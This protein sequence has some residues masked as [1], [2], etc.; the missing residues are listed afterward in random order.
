M[1]ILHVETGRH[2]YG[3]ARQVLDLLRGLRESGQDRGE[4]AC[5]ADGPLAEAAEPYARVTPLRFRGETDPRLFAGL[6]EV[7]RERPPDLIHIHSRRGADFWGLLAARSAGI[8]AVLSRRVDNPEPGWWARWKYGQCAAVIVVSEGIRQ[9]LVREGV[10]PERV[11]VVPDAVDPDRFTEAWDRRRL[12]EELG[13]LGEGPLIGMIAQ[14]IERKGHRD[15]LAALPGLREEVPGAR[16]LLLGR[17]PLEEELRSQAAHLGVAD[18]VRFC[19]YRPDL[20]RILPAL[21]LVVHPA[22]MEGL[23]VALLEASA[24]GVPIVAARAGGIPEVVRE[25]VNG[26]LV[27]PRDPAGLAEAVKV[28]HR[29]PARARRLGEGGRELVRQSFS[30]ETMVQGNLAVYRSLLNGCG[31]SVA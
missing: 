7:L 10:P 17:G 29:D 16:L 25:G 15:L 11:T 22:R 12:E 9:V 31:W 13:P 3:G 6:R 18:M 24:A 21:D 4:L 5:A 20:D 30:L 27:E 28:L 19:G 1:R 8:P 14:L 2:L 26:I 23:G